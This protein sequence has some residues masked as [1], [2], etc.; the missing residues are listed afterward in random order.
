MNEMRALIESEGKLLFRDPV[1]WLASIALPSVILLIFGSMFGPEEPDQAFG[2]LDCER[3]IVKQ[4]AVPLF[5]RRPR[6][7]L[8]H[9]LG[10]GPGE[11]NRASLQLA[12]LAFQHAARNRIPA[13]IGSERNL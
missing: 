6:I 11:R 5:E 10:F 9:P 4:A 13:G 8:R 1:S 12:F 2:G 3:I 7:A